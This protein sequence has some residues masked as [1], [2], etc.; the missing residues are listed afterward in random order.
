MTA[1]AVAL[2]RGINVAG[3][4]KLSMPELVRALEAAGLIGVETYIQSGNVFVDWSKGRAALERAVEE[5]ITSRFGLTI[6]TIVRT[7]AE[8]RRLLAGAP[9]EDAQVARPKFLH[10][11]VAKAKLRPDVADVLTAKATNERVLVHE[12]TL[13]LDYQE[14][15]GRSKLTPAVVDKAA[16]SH[17]TM[18]NWNTTLEIARRLGVQT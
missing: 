11:G 5:V 17:V 4:N 18:R 1:R 13:F 2:L 16:G 15:A 7:S 3:K 10:V 8:W 12:D 14:G 6:P 9:F